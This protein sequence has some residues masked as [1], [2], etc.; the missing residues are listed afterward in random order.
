MTAYDLFKEVPIRTNLEESAI[1][2]GRCGHCG[3]YPLLSNLNYWCYCCYELMH[4][5]DTTMIYGLAKDI[6]QI[7][8]GNVKDEYRDMPVFQRPVVIE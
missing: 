2:K 3:E 4:K 6:D 8:K 1:E 7:N 5:E